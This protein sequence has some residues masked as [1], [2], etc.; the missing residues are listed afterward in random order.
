MPAQALVGPLGR[1]W[2]VGGGGRTPPGTTTT[3]SRDGDPD[4]PAR[5]AEPAGSATFCYALAARS[6]HRRCIIVAGEVHDEPG[7]GW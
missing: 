3:R 6:V 1:W 4:P 5:R 2:R 7:H